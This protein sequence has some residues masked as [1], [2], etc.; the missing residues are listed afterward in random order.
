[1][2]SS[3]NKNYKNLNEIEKKDELKE[4]L[5]ELLPSCFEDNIFNIEK[6][7][8]LLGEE[9]NLDKNEKYGLN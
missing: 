6:F 7:K 8:Q 1:M 5:K 2:D 3:N 4:K 9:N